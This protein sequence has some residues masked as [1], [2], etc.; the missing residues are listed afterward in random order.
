MLKILKWIAIVICLIVA[1][2]VGLVLG[3][4]PGQVERAIETQGSQQLGAQVDVG[5]VRIGL[6]PIQFTILDL[7]ATN[8]S[9]TERNI[10]E[11]GRISTTIEWGAL[12]ELASNYLSHSEIVIP[13]LEIADISLDQPRGS[14]GALTGSSQ[15]DSG[16]VDDE[17][18]AGPMLKLPAFDQL[19]SDEM[20]KIDLEYEKF[21]KELSSKK[22]QWQ[23][24]VD[25]LPQE[26]AIKQ[27]KARIDA[28][29]KDIKG[30]NV[31]DQVKAVSDVANIKKD[32]ESDIAEYWNARDALKQDLAQLKAEANQLK[33]A[34]IRS[35][36]KSF[37]NLSID[38]ATVQKLLTDLLGDTLSAWLMSTLELGDVTTISGDTDTAQANVDPLH[39]ILKQ[40]VVSGQLKVRD[41]KT[42]FAGRI[43]N[44]TNSP[45]HFDAVTRAEA[46]ADQSEAQ[47]GKIVFRGSFD[48][49][50]INQANDSVEIYV[51]KVPLSD[52]PLSEHPK[53]GLRIEQGIMSASVDMSRTAEVVNGHLVMN[54]EDTNW[55][56]AAA[57]LTELWGRVLDKSL[58]DVQV[59][60]LRLDMSGTMDEPALAIR[61]NL[62][63]LLSKGIANYLDQ[64]KAFAMDRAENRIN[65]VVADHIRKMRVDMAHIDGFSQQLLNQQFALSD[66]LNKL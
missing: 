24:R 12:P 26:D 46:E 17:E 40:A 18:S 25:S 27:Y 65:V 6:F 56:L 29:Q 52:L 14:D 38:N 9:Q 48:H 10:V 32:I 13:N 62:D 20:I 39:F 31:L 50:D 53:F 15:N 22:S 2:A 21:R 41:Y 64:Q 8:P 16:G 66:F 11:L 3:W 61:S 36:R 58:S 54:V 28:F 43:E 42:P 4:V 59:L 35:L 51:K 23:A 49:R 63:Q 5:E 30:G 34:P 19:I 47:L 37:N 7:R 60:K 55:R 45:A 1:G 44:I 33:D 57:A